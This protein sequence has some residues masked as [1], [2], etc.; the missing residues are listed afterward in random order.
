MIQAR[1]T[2]VALAM[3]SLLAG[4]FLL[5]GLLIGQAPEVN[6]TDFGGPLD[7]IYTA[8]R[9]T[10][11]GDVAYTETHHLVGQSWVDLMNAV[12]NVEGD[13]CPTSFEG[14][15]AEP[16]GDAE[17]VFSEYCAPTDRIGDVLVYE[18]NG[19]FVV[20]DLTIAEENHGQRL[21]AETVENLPAGLQGPASHVQPG[22]PA[23]MLSPHP[24]MFDPIRHGGV[25][26]EAPEMVAEVLAALDVEE[27]DLT[28][29]SSPPEA[30]PLSW[31][32][33]MHTGH[34][35]PLAT[36][37]TDGIDLTWQGQVTSLG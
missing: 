1:S 22:W 30:L 29:L 25:E 14:L 24:A 2:W 20:G 36:E 35:F 32:V 8:E 16:A 19:T 6:A 12:V 10:P 4:A 27:S 37:W 21:P 5:G 34:S 18:P 28:V 17:L 11:E 9:I 26:T 31:T 7:V 23:V 15:T 33:V 13:P 3:A